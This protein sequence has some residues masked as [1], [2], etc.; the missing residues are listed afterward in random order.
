LHK[1][2]FAQT[3]LLIL[4]DNDLGSIAK[5]G[6]LAAD[7]DAFVPQIVPLFVE[8]HRIKRI[9]RVIEIDHEPAA[10]CGC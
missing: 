1:Y 3:K 7:L 5:C 4:L 6:D 2:I 10:A 8:R 9:R